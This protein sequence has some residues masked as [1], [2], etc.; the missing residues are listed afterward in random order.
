MYILYIYIYYIKYIKYYFTWTPSL[1]TFLQDMSLYHT[2]TW[3]WYDNQPATA[4]TFPGLEDLELALRRCKNEV[5]ELGQRFLDGFMLMIM[6]FNVWE[7]QLWWNWSV[8]TS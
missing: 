4:S 5:W 6:S 8:E 2:Y 1:L 7:N 3:C